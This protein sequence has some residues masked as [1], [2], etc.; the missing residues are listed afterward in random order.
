MI[1]NLLKRML[2]FSLC[3]VLLASSV[4]AAVFAAEESDTQAA[5]ASIQT[6]EQQ[7]IAYAKSLNFTKADD[8]AAWAL[9]RHG[10]AGSGKQLNVGSNHSLTA[11]LMN[12][13]LAQRSLIQ[14]CTVGIETM[15]EMGRSSLFVNGGCNWNS[16]GL[17]YRTIVYPDDTANAKERIY[18]TKPLDF[19]EK[20]NAYDDSLIWMSGSTIVHIRLSR[21]KVTADTVTY[22][23]TVQFKDRFDF[24]EGKHT[25]PEKFASLIGSALFREFDWVATAKFQLTAPNSTG[26]GSVC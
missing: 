18:H 7:I 9:T 14:G 22:D 11:T 23:V 13:K 4:P 12:S 10:L 21:A 20:T 25:A 8:D 26:D 15:Q 6:L 24:N 19:T 1:T 2:S 16:Q 3:M 5:S 17:T